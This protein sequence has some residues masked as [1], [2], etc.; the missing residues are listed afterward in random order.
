MVKVVASTVAL[1]RSLLRCVGWED[2]DEDAPAPPRTAAPPR[3]S[4]LGA[5]EARCVRRARRP[6]VLLGMI[7]G[8]V[9]VPA[10]EVALLLRS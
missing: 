3:D 2:E 8:L 10:V 9:L 7:S 6:P 4:F 5:L 1:R